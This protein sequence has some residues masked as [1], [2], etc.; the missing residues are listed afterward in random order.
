MSSPQTVS[1][2]ERQL[3][4]MVRGTAPP[5]CENAAMEF[6][7]SDVASAVSGELLGADVSVEGATIDSREV[8]VGSLFVPIVAVRDGHDFIQAAVD[9]G[10]AAHLTSGPTV[11]VP[12]VRVGDTT[13]AL[14]RLGA[15]ARD[16]FDA[17]GQAGGRIIGV[18]GSVGKTTTKDLLRAALA[19]SRRTHASFRSFNNELGVPLTLVQAPRDTEVVVVEMGAR[20]SGHIADLCAV[21]RPHVGV[22]LRVGAAHTELFGDV[23]G[24]AAA[25]GELVEALPAD[26]TAVLNTDDPLVMA[27]ATRT[28]AA[29]MTFGSTGDV[30]AEDVVLDEALRPR[31]RLVTPMGAVRCGLPSAGTHTVTNALAAAAAALVVGAEPEAIAEGL[32]VA[33]ISPWRMEVSTTPAGATVINDAYNAN[34]MSMHAA[35]DALLAVPASRRTAVVGVMAELGDRHAADHREIGE[36]LAAAG[37]RVVSLAVPEYG[38]T[39]VS[40]IDEAT[41]AVGALGPDDAVLIKGSRV[42]GL[43]RLASRLVDG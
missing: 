10:A 25:K 14:Q 20:G 38:G 40:D 16:R 15:A 32:A 27:M 2:P 43:E 31:F 12:A 11:G 6:R 3:R 37:V 1:P 22:V 18:T 4:A 9:A 23:A 33:E 35:I 36:R 5:C 19:G 39:E 41:E 21:A 26:G 42:A 28:H 30:R 24:V 7:L 8:P 17:G 34:T 13:T 29:V